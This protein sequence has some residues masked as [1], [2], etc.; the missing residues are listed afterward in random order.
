MKCFFYL[1]ILAFCFSA[2]FAQEKT[3]KVGDIVFKNNFDTETDRALW[4]KASYATWIKE[5][6]DGGTVLKV[7]LGSNEAK[8]SHLVQQVLNLSNLRGMKVLFECEVKADNV[9]KPPQSYNGLKVMFHSKDASGD[10]WNNQGNIYGSFDW[11][12]ISITATIP[13]DWISGELCLGLESSSGTAWFASPKITVVTAS[14]PARPKANTNL[15]GIYKGH[16][17][18]TLRGVMSPNDF[19]EEDFQTLEDWKVNLIR[20]QL[21][22]NW[23]KSGMEVDLKEYDSWID[24]KIEEMDRMLESAKRHHLLV[25]IDIHAPP[26]GRY[27]DSSMRMFYEKPYQDH[28]VKVWEKLATHFKNHPA[29]WAYDLINEP[30][31]VKPTKTGMGFL[32]T[33]ILA[34]KVIRKIDPTRTILIA[35]D[36]WDLPN[37]FKSLTA[38][39]IPNVVYQVHMYEPHPF[40]HQGI[41]SPVTGVQYPG[42]ISGKEWNKETLR[43]VLAPVREFQLAYHVQ[44]YAGEFSA[45]RWAPGAAQYLRDCAELFEE[46]GWDWSYHS[47]RE[48]SGWSLEHENEPV[49]RLKHTKAQTD[50]DRKKALQFFYDKNQKPEIK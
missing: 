34:A 10:H 46:Y 29:V 5:G 15:S 23:G 2:L 43:T 12:T 21:N 8:G 48:Y 22:R 39:D 35:A 9:S 38:V 25:V 13:D 32:D 1:S 45:I 16:A 36:N 31:E 49:D 20:W 41:E 44:I 28:F 19:K 24:K 30:V 11:K 27:E 4:S 50:T 37:A 40:T 47:F 33:Q 18:P 26:G 7:D 6:K 42:T 17:V 14:A 3:L